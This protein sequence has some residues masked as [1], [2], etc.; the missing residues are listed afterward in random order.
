[1]GMYAGYGTD[2]GMLRYKMDEQQVRMINP[3]DILNCV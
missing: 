1:M 2:V 3:E